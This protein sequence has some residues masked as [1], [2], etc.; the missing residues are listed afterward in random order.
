MIMLK[1]ERAGGVNNDNVEKVKG[2]GVNKWKCW[3]RKELG[4]K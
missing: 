3:K 1:K 2:R 4:C